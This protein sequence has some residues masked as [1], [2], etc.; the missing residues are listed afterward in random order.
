[1]V[2]AKQLGRLRVGL[3]GE[4]NRLKNFNLIVLR[5]NQAMLK[6]YVI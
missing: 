5:P 2:W 6:Q 3:L 1:V 4:I